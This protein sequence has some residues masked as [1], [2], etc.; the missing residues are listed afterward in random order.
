M[1]I[2][3]PNG[4]EV[5]ALDAITGKTPATGWTLRLYTA[6]SPALSN[7]TVVGHLTQAAGGGY[8]GIALTAANWVTTPGTPT[9]TAYPKQTFTFTGTLT[10]NA[11]VI[12]YYIT[13]ADGSL[14]FAEALASFQPANNGDTVDVTPTFTLGSLVND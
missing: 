5:I 8:A 6:I 4:G 14:V 2:T 13:R 10:G 12:G 1:S 9:S 11:T 7:A 3:V